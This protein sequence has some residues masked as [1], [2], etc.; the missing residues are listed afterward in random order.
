[1]ARRTKV[2]RARQFFP[3]QICRRSRGQMLPLR[4]YKAYKAYK[5]HPVYKRERAAGDLH[6]L[7]LP[8]LPLA[9]LAGC[10]V[11]NWTTSSITQSIRLFRASTA[12]E[13]GGGG[14]GSSRSSNDSSQ[15][16]WEKWLWK[17]KGV[18]GQKDWGSHRGS[19]NWLQMNGK[20]VVHFFFFCEE[21]FFAG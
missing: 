4:A 3:P 10:W 1:M 6:C 16:S 13:G 18:L 14:R 19:G 7:T 17:G 15:W 12:F 21:N 11:T 5:G 9:S 2:E 20:R 8:R